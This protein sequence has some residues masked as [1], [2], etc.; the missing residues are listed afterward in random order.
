MQLHDEAVAVAAEHQHHAIPYRI[1]TK[2]INS[3]SRIQFKTKTNENKTKTSRVNVLFKVHNH[4]FR[5]NV[6]IRREE[7]LLLCLGPSV[8]YPEPTDRLTMV[9][10]NPPASVR[11][12]KLL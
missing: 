3:L 4:P 1:Q 7:D 10:T 8:C 2:T 11:Y 12:T 6:N 9:Y 5:P